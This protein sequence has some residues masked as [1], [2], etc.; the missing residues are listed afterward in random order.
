MKPRVV[1]ADDHIMVAE[2]LGRLLGEVVDLVGHASNG[3]Q[4]IEVV[5]ELSPDI[6]VSDIE[7]PIVSGLDALR[8]LRAKGFRGHF[9]LLTVHASAQFAVE[10]IREGASGYLVKAAAGNELLEAITAILEGRIY[11]SPHVTKDVMWSLLHPTD[12]KSHSLTTRQ[13]EFLQLIT[14]GRRMKEIATQ[15]N[16]SVRTAEDHKANLLAL[17]DL[18]TTADLIKF[19]VKHGIAP[20]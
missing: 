2:G 16:I 14:Q 6:V 5:E 19:A 9:L 3:Q 7:M 18:K 17:L 11:L 12:G 20:D 8:Q 4:L 15:M 13:R 10:A 1:L